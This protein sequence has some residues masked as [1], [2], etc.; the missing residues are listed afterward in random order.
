MTNYGGMTDYGTAPV[1]DRARDQVRVLG[2]IR[3]VIGGVMVLA[4]ATSMRLWIGEERKTFGARMLT[5]AFGTREIAIGV[6]A[7]LAVDHDAP[8]RGWLEAGVLV[9]T[10]D[11][12]LT[13]IS[14]RKLPR[15]GRTLIVAGAGTGAVMGGRLARQ[16]G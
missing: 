9:D 2:I 14:Y 11:A 5:R 7:V 15:F 16:L 3:A 12:L 1:S 4:P 10:S 6:G 13:L 8:V